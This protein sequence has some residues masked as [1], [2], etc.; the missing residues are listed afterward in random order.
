MSI[1]LHRPI[2]LCAVTLATG[3]SDDK[4]M[5]SFQS[6]SGVS[7][8]HSA[9]PT[10]RKHLPETMGSGVALLDID[11][12]GRLD[13][14][15]LNGAGEKHRLMRNLGNFRFEDVSEK[16]GIGA[17]SY[18]MG[19]AVGD[20]NNDGKADLY[21]TSV[22]RNRLLRNTGNRFV[23]VT[24]AAGVA[25]SGWSAG[26]AFLDYDRDGR[27]DLFVS[28]YLDWD[29]GKSKWCGE[30]EGTPRS[31]C[32]P[33]E[34]GRVS[35]VLFRN[36]GDGTFED[37]SRRAGIEH[38]P[39]KGLGV[40]VEDV[41]GDRWPD[42]LVANDSVAQQ[43]FLNVSGERFEE[44]ALRAGIAYD[45]NGNTYAGMGI[46]AIDVDGDGRSDVIINA[47][48]RQGYWFYKNEGPGR[49]SPASSASGLL[50]LTEMRSGWGMR[51][52][53]FDN[54]GWPDL[55]VAQGH[56]MDTIEWSD[57]SVRYREPPL[58]A[59]NVFG[60]FFDVGEQAGPAFT[61][62]QA[63]R[64]LAMGDLD[65]DGRIDI[66][67]NNNN[68]AATVLKNTTASTGNWLAIRLEGTKSNRDGYGAA[69]FV[70]TES[71]RRLRMY[72]DTAGSYLSASSPVLHWG[73]GTGQAKSIEVLWPSGGRTERVLRESDKSRTLLLRE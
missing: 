54:D 53:D 60:K 7:F 45:E 2:I 46:D 11:N 63:G 22:G 1:A 12:D 61:Q 73:L 55:A 68:S 19:A 14:L 59:R 58:L 18:G 36:R 29:L 26:A 20:Y 13:I 3:F 44:V 52:A 38:K 42:I 5:L 62:A 10:E 39:G 34:F 72:A 15:F 48:A 69:V 67:I 71:G 9:G 51:F 65:N 4:P 17:D 21:L 70:T 37:V 56:V 28:R 49:F 8:G 23:D 41:N 24:L 64:G 47:L 16:W 40:K 31:Y 57:P 25:G 30:G 35:H 50:P 43:V 66:V 6:V 32:H 27:L 33:R